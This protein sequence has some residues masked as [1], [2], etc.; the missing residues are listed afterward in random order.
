[1]WRTRSNTYPVHFA[2]IK[3]FFLYAQKRILWFYVSK[4]WEK[5]YVF[6]SS[7]AFS[8]FQLPRESEPNFIVLCFVLFWEMHVCCPP[9]S[10]RNCTALISPKSQKCTQVDLRRGKNREI[11]ACI[12]YTKVGICAEGISET[13]ASVERY[14]K[15]NWAQKPYSSF[16]TVPNIIVGSPPP[17]FSKWEKLLFPSPLFLQ[18]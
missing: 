9:R 2:R 15:L 16:F 11:L 1:M 14:K 5:G 13:V 7:F 12:V 4:L 8:A 6:L 3:F 10:F 17:P 18:W